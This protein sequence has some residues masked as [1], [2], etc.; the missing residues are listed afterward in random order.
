MFWELI[1]DKSKFHICRF[2]LSQTC[3][4]GVVQDPVYAHV[5]MH[6]GV[7]VC[8][9]A[10]VCVLWGSPCLHTERRSGGSEITFPGVIWDEG[11]YVCTTAVLEK[12]AVALR[13][14]QASKEIF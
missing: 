2:T 9:H 6:M 5:C 7:C 13:N 1:R 3:S 11:K 8:A 14:S 4:L 12:Y 10:G